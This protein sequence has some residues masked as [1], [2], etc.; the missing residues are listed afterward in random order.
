[1]WLR[2]PMDEARGHSTQTMTGTS[3]GVHGDAAD[4]RA[5]WGRGLCPL[6]LGFGRSSACP[7]SGPKVPAPRMPAAG[8]EGPGRVLAGRAAG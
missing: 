5:P 3:P 8:G 2:L 4:T 1:M 7:C 6:W